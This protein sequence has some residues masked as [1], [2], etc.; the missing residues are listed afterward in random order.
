MKKLIL[1]SAFL[2]GRA[3]AGTIY[4][5]VSNE[6]N[7]IGFPYLSIKEVI[8][9]KSKFEI[10]TTASKEILFIPKARLGERLDITL[11]A[12]TGYTQLLALTVKDIAPQKIAVAVALPHSL[13]SSPPKSENI[14]VNEFLQHILENRVQLEPI[15]KLRKSYI[16]ANLRCSTLGIFTGEGIKGYLLEVRNISSS[17]TSITEES[18]SNLLRDTLKVYAPREQLQAKGKM[19]VIIITKT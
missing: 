19:Q 15:K 17:L 5:N 14:K 10:E 12:G 9:D 11:I 6:Y 2:A 13:L 18:F 8:G 16:I 3:S 4:A 1:I 7:L